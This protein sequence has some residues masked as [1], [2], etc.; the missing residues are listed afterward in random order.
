MNISRDAYHEETSA[1]TSVTAA[2][3]E[4]LT[5]LDQTGGVA[6]TRETLGL[7]DLAQHGVSG[8]GDKGSGETS[9]ETRSKVNSGLGAVGGG[10]TVNGVVDSLSDLLVDDELGHGVGDPEKTHQQTILNTQYEKKKET[11]TA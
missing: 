7:V 6:L 5:D 10:V 4:L 9:N 11:L 2:D 8:L 3:T 1:N